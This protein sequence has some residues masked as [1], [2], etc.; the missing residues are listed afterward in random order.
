MSHELGYIIVKDINSRLTS[1]DMSHIVY[2][3]IHGLTFHFS[4]KCDE[5]FWDTDSESNIVL[6][7][8]GL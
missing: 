2:Y 4:I 5:T 8:F 7:N 3:L 6:S 1:H